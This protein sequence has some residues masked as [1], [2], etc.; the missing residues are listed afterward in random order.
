MHVDRLGCLRPSLCAG[1]IPADYRAER[2]ALCVFVCNN[3]RV[4]VRVYQKSVSPASQRVNCRYTYIFSGIRTKKNNNQHHHFSCGS[5][6]TRFASHSS[7]ETHTHCLLDANAS[8]EHTLMIL[9]DS[10]KPP[11]QCRRIFRPTEQAQ[12]PTAFHDDA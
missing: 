7:R 8:R 12:T 3:I 6:E 5:P 4:H 1:K 9:R 10:F 11:A 2:I